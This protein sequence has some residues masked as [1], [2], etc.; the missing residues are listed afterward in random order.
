[1]RCLLVFAVVACV[2][3]G[4]EEPER[5]VAEPK[6]AAQP[7]QREQPDYSGGIPYDAARKEWEQKQGR[8]PGAE[9]PAQKKARRSGGTVYIA[10]HSGS[11][12]HRTRNCSGLSRA[13][14]VVG[15]SP[16]EAQGYSACK[17]CY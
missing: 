1:M 6:P 13:K 17:K 12:Y 15:V 8:S 11:K 3:C 5:E 4:V 10:P 14:E 16:S 7:V 2:G 9:Q